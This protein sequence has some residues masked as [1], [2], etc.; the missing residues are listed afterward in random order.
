MHLIVSHTRAIVFG[1]DVIFSFNSLRF[2]VEIISLPRQIGHT[3]LC[4][5]H[6]R[7]E[8]LMMMEVETREYGDS[9][10]DPQYTHQKKS[11][12]YG[13]LQED[14]FLLYLNYIPLKLKFSTIGRWS[15]VY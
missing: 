13:V 1:G 12:V 3:R 4:S 11:D 14:Y 9:L 7:E 10:F 15:S 6:K 2:Q 5:A 8:T